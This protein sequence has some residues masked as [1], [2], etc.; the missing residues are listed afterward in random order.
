LQRFNLRFEGG[1]NGGET[2]RK[3]D[4][5]EGAS[6]PGGR[7]SFAVVMP[8]KPAQLAGLEPMM[9]MI[10][11]GLISLLRELLMGQ[12]GLLTQRLLRS[13]ALA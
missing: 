8:L 1:L 9:P 3:P 10:W 4:R 2:P 13:L 7:D 12:Q 11:E 5:P 6:R